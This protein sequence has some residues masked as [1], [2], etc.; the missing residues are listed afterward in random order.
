M[1]LYASLSDDFYVNLNLS[2][3]MELPSNRETI[4]HFFERLQKQYPTMNNFYSRDRGEYV[5]EEEKVHG[6]YR[7]AAVDSRRISSGHVNPDSVDDALEQHRLVLD[8]IPFGLSV[9]PLDCESLNLM[10]G[11]DFNYQGNHNELL[12]EALGMAPAFES[13]SD[14]FRERMVAY[15]PHIQFSMDEECRT[16]CRV[17]VETRTSAYHV[18]TRE[19]PQEQLSVY[20]T[21]RRYGSLDAGT[22]Y[23]QVLNELRDVC[24]EVVDEFVARDFLKPIQRTIEIKS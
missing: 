4:L 16:Q 22:E 2:T 8:W 12:A 18:K 3:E 19:F 14:K 21:A 1:G 17:S 15:E 7:W 9:S 5:L 10:F 20:V 23:T 24:T 11:F 13:V 6:R